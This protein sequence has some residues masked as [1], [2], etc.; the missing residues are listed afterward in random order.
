MSKFCR[1]CG[2]KLKR[3]AIKC[4]RCGE[5]V[6]NYDQK[7]AGGSE[8]KRERNNSQGEVEKVTTTPQSNS[9][10]NIWGGLVLMVGITL[11]IGASLL[12]RI[13]PFKRNG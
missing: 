12:L 6:L 10:K 8:K 9:S 11:G 7:E 2:K 13:D 4:P 5:N 3:G 1:H